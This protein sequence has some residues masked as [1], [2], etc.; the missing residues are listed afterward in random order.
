M[1]S[2]WQTNTLDEQVRPVV[3]DDNPEDVLVLRPHHEVMVINLPPGA[4]TFSTA[5]KGGSTIGEAHRRAFETC[6]TFDLHAAIVAL[7]GAGAFVDWRLSDQPTN[8][9]RGAN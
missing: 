8:S 4:L 7:L 6:I 5:I 1:A 3:V 9:H 2:I